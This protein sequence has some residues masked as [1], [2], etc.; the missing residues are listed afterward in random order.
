MFTP[1]L[2]ADPSAYTITVVMMTMAELDIMT[3]AASHDEELRHC[4][5]VFENTHTRMWIHSFTNVDLAIKNAIESKA[6]GVNWSLFTR[7]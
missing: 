1:A 3:R 5:I 4:V 2:T 7:P 6:W